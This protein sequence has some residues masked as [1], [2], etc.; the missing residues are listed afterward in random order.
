[1]GFLHGY[2]GEHKDRDQNDHRNLV[3][4]QRSGDGQCGRLAGL[5]NELA[6]ADVDV[7]VTF[8]YPAALAAKNSTRIAAGSP[9]GL[10]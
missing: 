10:A 3:F 7:I 9:P 1:M 2:V 8:G 4:E 5:V 6:A